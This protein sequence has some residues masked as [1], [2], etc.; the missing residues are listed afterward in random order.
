MELIKHSLIG[1]GPFPHTQIKMLMFYPFVSS[2][3]KNIP[4]IKKQ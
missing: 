2:R 1:E 3:E 4:N